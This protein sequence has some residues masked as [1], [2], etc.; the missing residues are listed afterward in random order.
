MAA[1]YLFHLVE[2]HSL[3][4]GN[5]RVG[6]AAAILFLKLNG[7]NIN[8]ADDEMPTLFYMSHRDASTSRPSPIFSETMPV[9][10]Q[11]DS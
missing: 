4:D 10:E 7:F 9:H 6:T 2:N 3:V 5:K 1:A 8:V 11:S